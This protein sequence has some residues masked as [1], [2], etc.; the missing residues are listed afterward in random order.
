MTNKPKVLAIV[1]STA[2]GKTALSIALAQAL[3][4]EIISC[5]SMQLYRRMDIGTAKPTSD[6]MQGIPHHLIDIADPT[7]GKEATYSCADYVKDAKSA[8]RDVLS[9]SKLP[10]VCGGTGLYLDALIRGG[11]F[12]ETVVDES[13][14][15]SLA[16]FARE[17]G[18][19]ALHD[20]L[21]KSDPES[22]DAIHPNNVKRVI[23]ALE[24][25]MTT[26]ITKSELDRKSREYESEFDFT[27]IGIR[28]NDRAVLY[29]RIGRRVDQMMSD[30]LIEEAKSLRALGV[31]ELCPTAAQAIG[32]KEL[33]PYL[34]G[35]ATLDEVTEELKAATRRYAKR[36]VTWF[37]AR[38]YVHWIDADDGQNLIDFEDIV[39]NA[40]KVFQ[41]RKKCDII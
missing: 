8:I 23:R 27:V 25:F 19:E 30:G 39:N 15:K 1:G 10:I 31:F 7:D 6:E 29:D 26:G 24:I 18:N 16:D 21:R 32:Y 4:G 33:F 9:R 14:R 34:D 37:S 12:E 2:S 41:E 3:D 5:D 11:N 40:K 36:Q 17:N 13:L 22:A 35:E 38:P 20:R 28:Y